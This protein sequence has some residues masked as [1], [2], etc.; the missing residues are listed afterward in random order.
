MYRILDIYERFCLE[1]AAIPVFKG[2]KSDTERFAGAQITTSIEAM[3]WDKRALQSG[4][5][6]YFGDNFAKAF[7]INS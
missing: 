2:T 6:H 3:M 5:S 4:T 1:E 7:E